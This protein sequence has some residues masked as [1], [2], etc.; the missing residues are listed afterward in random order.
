MSKKRLGR[1][2]A[3]KVPLSKR[4]LLKAPSRKF[5]IKGYTKASRSNQRDEDS[6]GLNGTDSEP[7]Y[8]DDRKHGRQGDTGGL[9]TSKDPKDVRKDLRLIESAVRKGWNIKRKNM[10]VRRL[11]EIVDKTHVSVLTKQGPFDSEEAADRNAVAAA[12][13]LVAMN[14]Q[15]QA[16]DHLA[17]KNGQPEPNTTINIHNNNV[18]IDQ[19]RIELARLADKF[20]ARELVVNGE[21]V[22][23]TEYLKSVSE[24]SE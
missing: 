3:P 19:R 15:D 2:A 13:V 5:P 22:S 7:D 23:T 6:N 10:I 14:G 8:K 21:P 4:K 16:D 17:V 20:G 18:N 9:L 12:R 11:T 1:K 24:P